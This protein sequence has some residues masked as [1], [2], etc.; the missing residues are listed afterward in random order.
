MHTDADLLKLAVRLGHQLLSSHVTVTVAES[1]TAG[2]ICK[3]ITDVPG[4]SQWFGSGYVT[5]SNAAKHRELGVNQET[6]EKQG[7]VSEATVREMAAGA[8]HRSGADLALAV[9]GIAGPDGATQGKPVGTVWFALARR[10]GQAVEAV[11]RV[12]F[13]KGDREEVR[14]KAVQFALQLILSA[15]FADDIQ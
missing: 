11:A 1:C 10:R 2:W 14:R 9:S 5:Y 3:C 13:F 4:S 15:E 7:A 6:L 12:K 8:L